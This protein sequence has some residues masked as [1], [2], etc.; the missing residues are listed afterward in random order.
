MISYIEINK[1]RKPHGQLLRKIHFT[2][3][4]TYDGESGVLFVSSNDGTVESVYRIF[5]AYTN[6]P[7]CGGT[8]RADRKNGGT[9]MKFRK[10]KLRSQEPM[11]VYG[12]TVRCYSYEDMNICVSEEEERKT[13]KPVLLIS[14][15]GMEYDPDAQLLDRLLRYFG[16]DMDAPVKC[17]TGPQQKTSS[18]KPGIYFMQEKASA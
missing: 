6:A 17:F 2:F 8:E 7:L 4:V 1:E 10:S 5:R 13:R 12:H 9:V 16:M 3:P 11:T 14:F 15:A 18:R